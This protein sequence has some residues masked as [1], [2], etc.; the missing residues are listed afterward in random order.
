MHNTTE[1]NVAND[2][3]TVEYHSGSSSNASSNGL[4]TPITPLSKPTF[5]DGWLP[6]CVTVSACLIGW[7]LFKG[8]VPDAPIAKGNRKCLGDTFEAK[9]VPYGSAKLHM[10]EELSGSA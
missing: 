5:D 7:P 8:V 2:P 1:W 6:M 4:K 3:S 10:A 9:L